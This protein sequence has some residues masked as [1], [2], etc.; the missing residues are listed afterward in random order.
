VRDNDS[1]TLLLNAGGRSRRMGRP[2]ALL[3]L[4]GNGEP[5]IHHIARRLHPLASGLVV[6]THL[7][8]VCQALAD[9]EPLCVADAYPDTGPLGGLATGLHHTPAWALCVACDMPFVEPD[10]VRLLRHWAT[11]EWD[12][13]VPQAQGRLQPLLA[14]YHRR[15][16]GP[17]QA[18]L[19][20]GHYRM[21][22]WL[23]RVRTRVV[24]SQELQA[25]DPLGRSFVNV[26][27]P[28]DWAAVQAQWDE[29]SHS[30]AGSRTRKSDPWST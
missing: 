28:E 23:H 20:E 9:L 22:R 2:K 8:A 10:L 30:H 6:V 17:I 16:L 5:L 13:V 29:A 25:V 19:Q 7:P 11:E 15:C 21:D 24:S 26:N 1:L 14:L 3:R 4:P 27:T 18:A 12:A